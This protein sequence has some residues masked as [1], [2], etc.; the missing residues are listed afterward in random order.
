MRK[1]LL[2]ALLLPMAFIGCKKDKTAVEEP[3]L[4]INEDPATFA[5]VGSFDVGEVGAAEISA[6]DPLTKRLFVVKNEN[7]D[8]A[9]KTPVNQIEIIDFADPSNMKSIGMIS[10]TPFG[11]AV[12]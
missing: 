10:M 9:G 4:F 5:E 7:E 1:F 6:F 11:G 3:E 12:N 8:V 2:V